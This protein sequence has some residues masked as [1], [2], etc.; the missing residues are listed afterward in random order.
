ML[1]RLPIEP[2][3]VTWKEVAADEK[4]G[5]PRRLLAVLRYSDADAEKLAAQAASHRPPTVQKFPAEQWFPP[6]LVSQGELSGES[7]LR[8]QSYAAADM[9]QPPYTEGTLTRIENT[10]YFVLDLIVK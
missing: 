1:I 3:E 10:N 4:A 7:T 8:G 2:D 5:A 9:L 6:E